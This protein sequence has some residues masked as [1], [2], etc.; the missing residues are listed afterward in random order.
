MSGGVFNMKNKDDK[1]GKEI[2]NL[3]FKL[4]EDKRLPLEVREEYME[5]ISDVIN[6]K[7]D[8]RK[9]I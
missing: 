5:R 6:G 1:K 2:F 7:K 3:L 9:A 8:S 4:L